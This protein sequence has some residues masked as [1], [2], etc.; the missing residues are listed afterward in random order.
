M[1]ELAVLMEVGGKQ[2]ELDYKW[3]FKTCKGVTSGV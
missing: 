2:A 3:T 1:S